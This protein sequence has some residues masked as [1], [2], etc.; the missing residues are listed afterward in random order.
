MEKSC[1]IWAEL[2][3]FMLDYVGGILIHTFFNAR[4]EFFWIEG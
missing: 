2:G 3:F 4:V 1:L